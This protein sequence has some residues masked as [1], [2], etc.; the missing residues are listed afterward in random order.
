MEQPLQVT[1]RNM[2]PSSAVEDAV[3]E[4]VAKL[5]ELSDRIQYCRVVV[6]AP[7]RRHHQGT[8]YHVRV[9]LRMPGDEL[10]VRR[11]SD[12]DHAHEDVYVAVRD[13]FDAARRRLQDWLR[14]HR[15][16]VKTHAAPAAHPEARVARLFPDAAYGFL[17]TAD[18]REIYFHANAVRGTAFESLRV[19]ATVRF[20]EAAGLKGPQATA[21]EPA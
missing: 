14:R 6:E 10:V 7:H 4:R 2:D 5:E 12:A 16:A 20:V 11:D 21:V 19:G 8:L 18:G 15:G 1:F 9:E 3:R 17:E 13:A